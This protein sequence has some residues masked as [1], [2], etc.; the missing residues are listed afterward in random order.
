VVVNFNSKLKEAASFGQPITEYDPASRGMQ[1]F[2]KL[3]GW[4]LANPVEEEVA[5]TTA[6]EEAAAKP[7]AP[8]LS[9]AAELVERARALSA[10]TAALASRLAS[11]PD[12][13]AERMVP[14]V[15]ATPAPAPAA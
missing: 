15:P 8:A 12:V 9:R 14:P 3:A 7:A 2:D 5:A 13:A 11:D 4:L 1:D 10:R 6:D